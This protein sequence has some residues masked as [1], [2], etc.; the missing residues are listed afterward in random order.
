M[1][2]GLAPGVAAAASLVLVFANSTS[3]SLYYA[4]QGRI[5]WKIVIP[6]ALAAIPGSVLGAYLSA[7]VSG[8]VF[9]IAYALFL[10]AVAVDVVRNATRKSAPATGVPRGQRPTRW[11]LIPAGFVVGLVSSLFGIGGGVIVVPFLLYATSEEMHTIAATS[12]AII[13]LAAPVGICSQILQG[14]LLVLPALAL[15]AGGLVGGQAGAMFSAR[16]TSRQLSVALAA[17]MVVAAAGMSLRHV[18]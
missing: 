10:V 5:A 18:L 16:I 15:G 7:R 1:F 11:L 13:A 9:D 12:T 2:F 4:R 14:D 6:V 3:A 17:A 8:P